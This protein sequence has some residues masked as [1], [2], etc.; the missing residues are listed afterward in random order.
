MTLH[1]WSL[2]RGSAGRGALDVVVV[3]ALDPAHQLAE[4]AAHTLDRVPL[5]LLAELLELRAT[6]VLVVD[7]ALRERAVLDVRQHL[8]HPRLHARVD[9][10]RAGDVVAVLRGVGHR[11]ALL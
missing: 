7:E 8:L 6:R 10:A 3:V 9:D 5:A 2:L 1:P 11:P 4:L